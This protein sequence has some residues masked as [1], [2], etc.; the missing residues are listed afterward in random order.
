MI[1]VLV[2]NAVGYTHFPDS[3]HVVPPP[4]PADSTAA[5]VV[6]ALLLTLLQAKAYPLL[7]FLFGWS[8]GHSFQA[9]GETASTHRRRRL[10]RLLLIGLLHGSLIYAGDV[11]T[12]YALAGFLL[13]SSVRW[14]LRRL[15][16]LWWVLLAA[17]VVCAAL[18][19]W[20]LMELSAAARVDPS[21]LEQG[22][23]YGQ[24]QTLLAHVSITW[25]TYL[26]TQLL[27]TPVMLPVLMSLMVSGLL[28][29]RL[30][31]FTH[32]RWRTVW[33]RQARW[34]LPL[35]LGLNAFVSWKMMQTRAVVDSAPSVWSAAQLLVGPVLT[36][37]LVALVAAARPGWLLALAP[38]GRRS[39]SLYLAGS[40]SFLL[41]YGGSG[42]ALGPSLGSVATLA[43][44]IGLALVLSFGA[45]LSVR[46]GRTGVLERWLSS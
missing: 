10:W 30:R 43:V 9:R 37:G 17:S 7:A 28:V 46:L 32:R 29:S 21:I 20:A 4:V 38:V 26:W 40:L 19:A 41:V 3:L 24:V 22:L 31:G 1:G 39:L 25:P 12:A 36:F 45:V 11:L 2:V 13:L 42:L 33:S 8:F 5:W 34:A 18:Q 44:A 16:R 27:L 35:G 6:Q 15:V 23:G 14:R